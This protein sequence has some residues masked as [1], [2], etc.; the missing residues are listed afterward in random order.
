[1]RNQAESH[2]HSTIV[3]YHTEI[4]IVEQRQVNRYILSK[5]RNGDC[6]RGHWTWLNRQAAKLPLKNID[7]VRAQ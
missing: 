6:S 1:M 3:D 5:V 7:L 2:R 4:G